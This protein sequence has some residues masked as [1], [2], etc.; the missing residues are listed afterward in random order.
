MNGFESRRHK[1]L[2]YIY[3][4][5]KDIGKNKKEKKTLTHARIFTFSHWNTL[6]RTPHCYKPTRTNIFKLMS[7]YVYM[8]NDDYMNAYEEW[9]N[10]K[11][12]MNA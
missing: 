9:G 5:S 11:K 1:H 8:S 7:K 3:S 4:M 2:L 6:N 10:I 12:T